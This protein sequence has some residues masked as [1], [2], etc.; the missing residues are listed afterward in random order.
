MSHADARDVGVARLDMAR[1][2]VLSVVAAIA[3]VLAY[4][5]GLGPVNRE[6]AR[7]VGHLDLM[8]ARAPLGLVARRAAIVGDTGR[9]CAMP[10]QPICRMRH[11]RAMALDAVRGLVACLA[12]PQVAHTVRLL[13]ASAVSHTPGGVAFATLCVRVRDVAGLAGVEVV[14]LDRWHCMQSSISATR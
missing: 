13:P 8:T 7:R 9:R 12:G 11:P 1:V 14:T 6:E 4:L 2:A 3:G 10:D 5:L